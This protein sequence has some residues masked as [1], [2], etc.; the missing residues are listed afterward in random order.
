MAGVTKDITGQRFGRLVAININRTGP[1]G[2]LWFCRCDCGGGKIVRADSLRS[3]ATRSCG[4][5]TRENKSIG[6]KTRTHGLSRTPLYQQWAAMLRRCENPNSTKYA[7][8]GGRGIKVCERWHSFPNFL[9]DMGQPANG[10]ELDRINNNGHY[11]SA[12]C[13][14]VTRREQ[15]QNTRANRVI[16]FNG[17]RKTLTA[18]AKARDLTVGTLWSR[19]NTC[20]WSVEKALLTPGPKK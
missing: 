5:L 7:D 2:A 17:E 3:G 10:L 20:D 8:Y 12:N 9:A 1:K 11:E 13:R 16:E 18:W 4:C 14:W 15:M 6:N 19:L